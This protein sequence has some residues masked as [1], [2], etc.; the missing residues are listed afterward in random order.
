MIEIIARQMQYDGRKINSNL[1]NGFKF[2]K[3]EKIR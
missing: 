2:I 1:K 3:T